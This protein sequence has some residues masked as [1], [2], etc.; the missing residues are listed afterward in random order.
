M[1]KLINTLRAIATKWRAG[2]QEHLGGVVLVWEGE[3]YGWKDELRDPD[4]ERPGAYAV[5]KAGLVFRA[6]GGDDYNGAKAWV[7]VDPDEQP[8]HQTTRGN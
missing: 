4:S 7:A 6:E 2:N 3:V 1:T 5:D 8:N